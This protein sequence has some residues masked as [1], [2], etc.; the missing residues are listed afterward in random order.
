MPFFAAVKPNMAIDSQGAQRLSVRRSLPDLRSRHGSSGSTIERN[1]FYRGNRPANA[2]RIVFT[3]NTD[4]NQSLLQVRAGQIDYDAGGLP[5]TAHETCRASSAIRKGGNGRYFVNPRVDVDV[6]RAEHEPSG[7]SGSSRPAQGG[8]LRDRPSR[9]LRVAGK[10][11]AKRL[12]QI[13]APGIRGFRDARLYPLKGA[14][15]AAARKALGD[16]ANGDLDLLHSA[17]G[18]LGRAGAG[19]PV[20]PAARSACDVKLKPQP[21]AVTIKTAGTRGSDFDMFLICG[22]RTTRIRSTSSTCCST[23]TTSRA[24]TTRTTRT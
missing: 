22:S 3:T 9:A 15:P 7:A 10:F 24:R 8:Q 18:D 2:D 6:P 1:R 21:F 4:L 19:A 20:Q 12:D 11:A 23:G 16:P 5:P 13:L 17:S 14:D